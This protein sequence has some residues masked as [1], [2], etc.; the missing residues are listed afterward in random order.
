MR[1]SF[2]A[3]SSARTWPLA[4]TPLPLKIPSMN[5]Y[6]MNK[7]FMMFHEVVPICADAKFLLLQLCDSDLTSWKLACHGHVRVNIYMH[8]EIVET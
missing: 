3:A 1:T 7:I 4:Y 2:P 8:R 6:V 5:S